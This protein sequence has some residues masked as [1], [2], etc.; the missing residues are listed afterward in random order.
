MNCSMLSRWLN[1]CLYNNQAGK[2]N[3]LICTIVPFVQESFPCSARHIHI[4]FAASNAKRHT[5]NEQPI[6]LYFIPSWFCLTI[7]PFDHSTV[8]KH[9]CSLF[10]SCTLILS[11]SRSTNYQKRNMRP[12][13][14]AKQH[15][16]I[17]TLKKRKEIPLNYL[18][19][20]EQCEV[21]MSG[22]P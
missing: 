19:V 11:L 17:Q 8:L 2:S 15:E 13:L 16:K 14:T 21:A 9:V 5:E 22:A 7:R 20:V 3:V 1:Y 12:L 18:H 6:L 10:F 4:Y